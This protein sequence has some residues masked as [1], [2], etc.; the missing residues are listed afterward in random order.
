[1]VYLFLISTLNMWCSIYVF[2]PCQ[3]NEKHKIAALNFGTELANFIKKNLQ[4]NIGIKC[5]KSF[6]ELENFIKK[7]LQN[8]I[9]INI[10]WIS[11]IKCNKSLLYT[12]HLCCVLSSWIDPFF[13]KSTFHPPSTTFTVYVLLKFRGCRSYASNDPCEFKEKWNALQG[14]GRI[15]FAKVILRNGLRC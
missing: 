10:T 15:V 6:F 3:R 12:R 11:A 4:N 1:M 7:Y 9:R 13:L 14:N 8:N 5:K 2:Q